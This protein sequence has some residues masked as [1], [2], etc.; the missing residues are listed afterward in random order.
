MD[1]LRLHQLGEPDQRIPR[2][3]IA[4]AYDLDQNGLVSG[5]NGC[6]RG[7]LYLSI[8]TLWSRL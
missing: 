4:R 5:R 7:K 6:I 3:G 1:V 2:R 8:F